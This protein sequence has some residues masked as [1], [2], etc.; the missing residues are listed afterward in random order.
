M[1]II[2]TIIEDKNMVQMQDIR[3]ILISASKY[4]EQKTGRK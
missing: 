1:I 2:I 3:G 4:L